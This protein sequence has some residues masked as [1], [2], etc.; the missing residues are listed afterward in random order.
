MSESE[1][2]RL[3][4]LALEYMRHSTTC[5]SLGRCDCGLEELKEQIQEAIEN[6]N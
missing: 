3:L 5:R 6:D 4:E 2:I 1:L